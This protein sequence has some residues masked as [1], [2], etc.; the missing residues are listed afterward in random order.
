[1]NIEPES[2]ELSQPIFLLQDVSELMPVVQDK[3][4]DRQRTATEAILY[5]MENEVTSTSTSVAPVISQGTPFSLLDHLGYTLK[6]QPPKKRA[7]MISTSS[8]MPEADSSISSAV[9]SPSTSTAEYKSVEQRVK[10]N[11]ASRRSRKMRKQKFVQQEQQ[12]EHLR[13]VNA[14]LRAK[15]T[16]TQKTV[17]RMKAILVK[18]LAK[19]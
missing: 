12:V 15:V 14:E 10:N 3:D 6:D 11:I 9:V 17:D 5:T 19:A 2:C 4:S 13:K 7:H 16:E 1:M 18:K 8:E